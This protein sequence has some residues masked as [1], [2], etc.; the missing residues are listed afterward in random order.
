MDALARQFLQAGLPLELRVVPFVV[1]A[2]VREL[3]I[4]QLDIA[5]GP[6]K[7]RTARGRVV[8]NLQRFRAYAGHPANALEVVDADVSLHQVVLR[9]DEPE[10]SF[11]VRLGRGEVAPEGVDVLRVERGAAVVSRS[12][13]GQVRHFLC[14]MDESHLFIAL[15]PSLAATVRDAHRALRPSLL[16]S[17]EAS[18]PSRAIRQGEWFFVPLREDEEQRVDVLA[19]RTYRVHHRKG[20]AETAGIRRVGRPHVAE[21]VVV[22]RDPSAQE[23]RVYVRGAVVHPDHKTI[24]LRGW[25]RTVPN[26]EEI[27]A[28]LPGIDWYD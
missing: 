6:L 28:P 1:D 12:T 15:L 17:L 26:T 3:D 22:V 13:T 21:D 16:D 25:H 5:E 8:T 9:V 23:D 19:R 24:V 20:I 10:R 7:N 4:V 11:E 14:G 18:A 27:E 2:G